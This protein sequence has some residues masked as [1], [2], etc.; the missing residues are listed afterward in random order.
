[1]RTGFLTGIPPAVVSKQET[2]TACYQR[3]NAIMSIDQARALEY[4]MFDFREAV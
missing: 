2:T 1:M 4:A 3:H